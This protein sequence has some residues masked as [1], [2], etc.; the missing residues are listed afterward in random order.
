[1]SNDQLLIETREINGRRCGLYRFIFTV[2]LILDYDPGN[3]FELYSGRYCYEH[4]ADAKEALHAWDGAVD[5]P[6]PWIKYKGNGG[7]R[8]NPSAWH[9]H[10]FA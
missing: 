9:P 8:S 4:L 7:E 5:P 1:M 10:H 3:H 6:G 2:G